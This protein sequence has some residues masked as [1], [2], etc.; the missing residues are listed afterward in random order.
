MINWVWVFSI[1]QWTE[2]G[3]NYTVQ[4]KSKNKG[5][6]EGVIIRIKILQ[7]NYLSLQILQVAGLYKWNWLHLGLTAGWW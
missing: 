6:L 4:V 3:T 7:L 2:L 5:I 1:W